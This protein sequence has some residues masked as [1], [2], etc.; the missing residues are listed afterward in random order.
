MIRQIKHRAAD[1]SR[2]TTENLKEFFHVCF[3]R[4]FRRYD[5]T[6]QVRTLRIHRKF[7]RAR[8][9]IFL[10]QL[11]CDILSADTRRRW[12]CFNPIILDRLALGYCPT[13][14]PTR[15]LHSVVSLWCHL[16]YCALRQR[17]RSRLCGLSSNAERVHGF[18]FL[19]SRFYLSQK[20]KIILGWYI[21][22]CHFGVFQRQLYLSYAY[23][24]AGSFSVFIYFCCFCFLLFCFVLVS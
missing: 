18:I 9:I 7:D 16:P 4:A 12:Y 6:G 24:S 23:C 19:I 22:L 11:S 15:G 3:S 2:F 10:W 13:Q 8:N 5:W 14:C 1:K 17:N 21:I 20:I